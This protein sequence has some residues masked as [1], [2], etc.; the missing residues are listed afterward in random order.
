MRNE[1]AQAVLELFEQHRTIREFTGEP[2]PPDDL[3]ALMAAAQ[4]APSG[5]T[6]QLGT[7][8]RVTDPALRRRIAELAANQEQIV[9]AS[10]FFVACVD[11]DRERR[12]IEYRGGRFAHAPWFVLFYGLVDVTLMANNMATAA[13]AMGYGV[14][15]IGAVQNNLDTVARILE[16]PR[17][18]LPVFGLCIGVPAGPPPPKKPRIP[19]EAAF[20]E[21]RYRP[22]TPEL[23]EACY[24]AMA[25]TT[26]TGDWYD[27]LKRYWA[28]GGHAER[29]EG[30]LRRTLAQQGFE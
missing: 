13:E 14:C 5:G 1:V 11:G 10:E 6:A 9:T 8:I 21:N 27:V 26:R 17:G 28:V 22:L 4:R 19:P 23:L 18:V 16:L 2:M 7:F 30:I 29:R 15:Y 25:S 20:M 12:L 3:R 24:E